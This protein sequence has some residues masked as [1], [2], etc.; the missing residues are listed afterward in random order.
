MDL[1]SRAI[2]EMRLRS[3]V[4]RSQHLE[5]GA[6]ISHPSGAAGIHILIRGRAL[7]RQQ[8]S[9]FLLAAGDLVLLPQ[10]SAHS[11]E[12]A[13]P[14]RIGER[15]E[16][17]S[18][19]LDF[20][21]P[22]HPLFTVLPPVVHATSAQLSSNAR[23]GGY[24]AQIVD[25][26]RIGRDGSNALAARLS[27]VLLI[28]VMRF[29]TPPAGVECPVGGWF[30]ALRDPA[31]RRVLSAIHEHPNRN[32]SVASLAKVASESRSAFAAHFVNVMRE[33]PMAYLA[34]WRM[35]RARALLRQTEL[36]L[37]VVAELVGYGSAAAFSLAFARAHQTAPGAYRRD[38]QRRREPSEAY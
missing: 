9:S 5:P 10:S 8:A 31:L 4:Y 23:V 30:S 36:P 19:C 24:V 37:D 15:A 21:S 20:E 1:M 38:W 3:A 16:L 6:P 33:P 27:E 2:D 32:W 14:H 25:E 12:R 22:D 26:V 34:R 7:L 28:E 17:L 18:A 29:F 35:F 11:L 13:E